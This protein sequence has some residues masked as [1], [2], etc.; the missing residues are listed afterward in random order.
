MQRENSAIAR[1]YQLFKSTS[2]APRPT[3]HATSTPYQQW[4][5]PR[6]NYTPVKTYALDGTV[7]VPAISPRFETIAEA[8][9]WVKARCATAHIPYPGVNE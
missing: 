4:V 1:R 6:E 9:Q 5:N 2:L 7:E 8:D 3:T